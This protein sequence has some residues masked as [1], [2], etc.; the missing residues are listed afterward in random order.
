MS[1]TEVT[2]LIALIDK[3]DIS[4]MTMFDFIVG[5][6]SIIDEQVKKALDEVEMELKSSDEFVY[7]S[8]YETINKLRKH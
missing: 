2:K 8:V 3:Y 4:A 7:P 1:N 6:E 5:I